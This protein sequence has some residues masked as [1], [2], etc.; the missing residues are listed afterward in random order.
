MHSALLFFLYKTTKKYIKMQQI[1]S[2][3]IFLHW[4]IKKKLKREN[5]LTSTR[6]NLQS[7]R[8]QLGLAAHSN[9]NPA[10]L[11]SLMPRCQGNGP[12]DAGPAVSHAHPPTS[13]TGSPSHVRSGPIRSR[14]PCQLTHSPRRGRQ[15]APGKAKPPVRLPY[16]A[17]QQQLL[18]QAHTQR[19]TTEN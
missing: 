3:T 12:R 16:A 18:T 19:S 17:P 1:Y 4:E 10:L 2:F 15:Q 11:T 14:C 5:N 9:N 8:P 7:K 13:I 6:Q